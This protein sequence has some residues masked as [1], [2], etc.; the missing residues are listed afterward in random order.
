AELILDSA[1]VSPYATGI[2]AGDTMTMT[3]KRQLVGNE[4]RLKVEVLDTGWDPRQR[5]AGPV[6]LD[7]TQGGWF[8]PPFRPV[9]PNGWADV[10]K[11]EGFELPA[12]SE[13][14]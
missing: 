7:V 11:R 6:F 13:E 14:K 8:P 10:A 1:V 5:W 12:K 4:Q 9:F 3:V 2:H